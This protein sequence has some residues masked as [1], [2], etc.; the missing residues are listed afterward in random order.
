M[1]FPVGT[2]VIIRP[3]YV[4]WLSKNY[5]VLYSV[6]GALPKRCAES[7]AADALLIANA[8]YKAR[9]TGYG[10][11]CVRVEK[12]FFGGKVKSTAYYEYRS[13]KRV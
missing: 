10:I 12:S 11:D 7:A 5:S 4:K 13:V 8:P 1:K 6:R 3:S 2:K 9:V